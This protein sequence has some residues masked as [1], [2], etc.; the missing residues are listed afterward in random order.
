MKPMFLLVHGAWH[1]GW[2]WEMI[3]P[4]LE[5][6]GHKVVAPDLPGMGHDRAPLESVSLESWAQLSASRRS[7]VVLSCWW[8][9]A[10]LAS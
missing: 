3:A 4:L 10:E 9:T 5:A 1:G 2:C 8:G 7:T 6:A